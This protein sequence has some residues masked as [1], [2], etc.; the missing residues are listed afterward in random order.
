LQV[1]VRLLLLSIALWLPAGSAIAQF[2]DTQPARGP[3]LG[4]E[5]TN[6]VKIG[7]VIQSTGTTFNAI[8]TVPVPTD[9]PEQ[10]VRIVGEEV[11]PNV[12]NL[13]YR[14]I[15]GGGGL[16]QMVVEVPQLPRGKEA[17]AL[18]TFEV[19]RRQV[20]PPLDTSKYSIPKRLPR[21]LLVNVGPS[22][23]IESRHPR[24]IAAARE[25]I[26]AKESTASLPGGQKVAGETLSD[27]EKVEALYDWTR[28]HVAFKQGKLKGAAR[29]LIDKQGYTDELASV[30]IALCRV[31]KIP[32]RTVFVKGHCYAEF[33]LED[34]TGQGHWF[35]CQTAG[36]RQFGGIDEVRPVL[37]KGDNFKNPEDTKEKLRWVRE[38]FHASGKGSSPKVKFVYEAVAPPGSV[39]Q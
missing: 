23:Y 20:Q 28:N 5:V 3:V 9:W 16:K 24:I 35:P 14:D 21:N 38:Y 18:V 34:E 11:S 7:V 39:A 30:F 29:G 31:H 26:A 10:Q 36:T 32:A 2:T 27:W 15:A 6:R 17:H 19:T 1:A 22:P 12:K 33:Y 25:A 37:Q 8:A 13:T 4:D